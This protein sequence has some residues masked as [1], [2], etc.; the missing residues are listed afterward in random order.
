VAGGG[1]PNAWRLCGRADGH[2]STG[3]NKHAAQGARRSTAARGSPGSTPVALTWVA[4]SSAHRL[5]D[6]QHAVVL[7]PCPR[8]LVQR[9]VGVDE[10]RAVDVQHPEQ[11]RASWAALWTCMPASTVCAV[12][13]N[14]LMRHSSVTVTRNCAQWRMRVAKCMYAVTR[15][16]CQLPAGYATCQSR[17]AAG[18]V[19]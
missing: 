1:L 13:R 18:G 7:G 3:C 10:K 11:A 14:M 16:L 5:V 8:V 15:K 4:E 12:C 9:Q 19:R 6:E 17:A 2:P